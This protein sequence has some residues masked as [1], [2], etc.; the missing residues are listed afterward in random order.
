MRRSK[1]AKAKIL[2][3][4]KM[5][6]YYCDKVQNGHTLKPIHLTPKVYEQ[7]SN[8]ST[9]EKLYKHSQGN[10]RTYNNTKEGNVRFFFQI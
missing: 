3:K 8:L 6:P 9:S 4:E 5:I 10:I 2:L 1:L 7:L